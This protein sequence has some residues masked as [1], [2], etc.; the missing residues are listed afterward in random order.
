MIHCLDLNAVTH[1]NMMDLDSQSF[2]SYH[3]DESKTIP[4]MGMEQPV[5]SLSNNI[6]SGLRTSKGG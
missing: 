5:V 2:S 6:S 1:T 4:G 3:T